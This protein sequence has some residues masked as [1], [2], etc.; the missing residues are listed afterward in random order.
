[1]VTHHWRRA[2]PNG[3]VITAQHRD[4]DR[5][6]GLFWP[7]LDPSAKGPQP[8]AF[9][10]TICLAGVTPGPGADLSLNTGLAEAALTAAHRAGIGRVLVASSSAVYGAGDGTP[11]SETARTDPVN[12]YGAAKLDMERACAPWRDKGVEVCCL[13]IGNVAGADAL[14]LNVARSA[15]DQPLVID[16]FADGRGPVRSY[17]GAR[18]MADVLLTLATTPRDLPEVLNVAAPGHVW[19]E[20][21][22]RA[23]G[24]PFD[25]R[26]APPTAYQSIT[27]ACAR[28]AALHDFAPDA[29]DPAALVTQWKETLPR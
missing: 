27:L 5:A 8:G 9:D 23:A 2:P 29:A 12:A 15:P 21:L 1:M 24:H 14:L 13:R 18:S 25:F 28:L 20:D 22:A 3:A 6:D 19:M 10:A 11:F 4:P 7:L 26:D 17:I 16:R